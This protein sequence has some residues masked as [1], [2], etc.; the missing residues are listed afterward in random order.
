MQ[1]LS[2][3]KMKHQLERAKNAVSNMRE[4]AERAVEMGTNTLLTTAG[5]AVGGV[6][7]AKMPV[8][9]GTEINSC[10]AIGTITAGLALVGAGGKMGNQ[11]NALGSGLLAVEAYEATK[12]ALSA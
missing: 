1:T 8:I 10:L 4:D 6:L 11:L 9:P 3:S 5:G 7:A 12:K 2:I